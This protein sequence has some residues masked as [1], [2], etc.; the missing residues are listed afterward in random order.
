[1]ITNM[2]GQIIALMAWTGALQLQKATL[3]ALESRLLL[4]QALQDE[5]RDTPFAYSL[6]AMAAFQ[7]LG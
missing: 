6:Y 1:M 2:F 5:Q 4:H 3:E 7:R